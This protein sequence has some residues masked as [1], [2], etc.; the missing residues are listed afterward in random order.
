M[1]SS[2]LL[3]TPAAAADHDCASAPRSLAGL[4]RDGLAAALLE[5]GAPERELR[6][7]TAQLWHWIYHRGAGSF[8][9]MLNVSK[10][11]RTQLAEKFTL[12]RPQIVTEQVSTDGTRKWLI[13]FAPSAESDRLAEVECVY[14]PDVDRGTLCV[15][16]QVGCTLTCSFC[17]TGTQKFVRNLT[18]Q[19][20][21]AQ[22]IIARDRIGD[23]PG[24]APRDG[25]GSNSGSRL[26]TNIVF[27]GMGEPLYNLDN[28]VDAVSVL[29]D[30]DGLSLSR[31]RITVSTAGVVPKL[32]ELGEKTGAMLAISLHAVRD[33]L[34]NTLVPL[35]KKYPIAALLQA[36]RDY[37]GASN[38]RR[39]TFEYVMLKGINDSP[40]DARELVRL[41][42]GIPA[43]INLIPFNPWPGTAYECSDDAVIEKFS[44][45]VFNAGYASPVRTP[46][47][48][49]ILA[50]CG[51][52]KSET[53]KLRARAL[54]VAGD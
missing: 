32:P 1:T 21:I 30:G 5:I 24:L 47:G 23:F 20:I 13:R 8:D 43:K 10:V 33:E 54:L 46:R 29:S 52:L 25:K 45:I 4:T 39:I 36:C 53:E 49:D 51:Q 41:L 16:S 34:R 37:P 7:R 17:H 50:A 22:L 44:D 26:V 27:M 19:E 3:E 48:R 35:N 15:S 14:I 40:S 6:M 18:A 11:L 31:R 38:A 12:A 28:V 2:T 9:D 42:K